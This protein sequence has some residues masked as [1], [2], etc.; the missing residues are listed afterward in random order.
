MKARLAFLPF[1][2]LLAPLLA[3]LSACYVYAA[4]SSPPP[5]EETAADSPA[6][7]EKG[8]AEGA[9]PA[10]S[11]SGSSEK[12]FFRRVL[13]GA[14]APPQK[15]QADAPAAPAAAASAAL[16]SSQEFPF[17]YNPTLASGDGGLGSSAAAP[18]SA[19]GGDALGG[20]FSQGGLAAGALASALGGEFS[21]WN[22]ALQD[23]AR[24]AF[25][26][27]NS[28]DTGGT[29]STGSSWWPS[30]SPGGGLGG[31]SIG[32]DASFFAGFHSPLAVDAFA[33][34]NVQFGDLMVLTDIDDTLWSSGS[35]AAFGKHI[36][37]VDP[38][39]SRGQPYPGLGTLYCLLALGTHTSTPS[40]KRIPRT[41]CPAK[42]EDWSLNNCPVE[43]AAAESV[44]LPRRPGVLSA[45]AST[46]PLASVTRP[47]SF[48]RDVDAILTRGARA[49]FGPSVQRWSVGFQNEIQLLKHVLAS[50]HARGAAKVWGFTEALK[51]GA[52][53]VVFGDTGEKDPEAA[54]GMAV[55]RPEMLAAVLLHYV[56][57][58]R[59]KELEAASRS[60]EEEGVPY[61]IP[62]PLQ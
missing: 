58:N 8:L 48:F 3:A 30:A 10:E 19:S 7:R 26:S 52:P 2:A 11:D 57:A 33:R 35:V 18:A 55:K 46:S 4:A 40:G 15:S 22:G 31:G 59:E 49:V 12:G 51:A 39:L 23:A 21:F 60:F 44:T 20:I 62:F 28:A 6:S 54:A 41:L 32:G 38:E 50:Q 61:A 47:A 27:S 34:L 14:E 24:R 25:L 29:S 53:T 37:G 9:F 42:V 36:G 16:P 13:E 17:V 56:F 1:F 43:V 45:R 5:A